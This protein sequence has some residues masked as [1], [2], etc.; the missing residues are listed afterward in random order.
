MM[1]TTDR[2]G[3]SGVKQRS[4]WGHSHSTKQ[5]KKLKAKESMEQPWSNICTNISSTSVLC[6][7]EISETGSRTLDLL[8]LCSRAGSSDPSVVRVNSQNPLFL[9]SELYKQHEVFLAVLLWLQN[10]SFFQLLVQE[11]TSI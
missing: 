7:S 9:H 3:G 6:Y 10:Q 11:Q 2:E 1:D 5:I 4:T 8:V